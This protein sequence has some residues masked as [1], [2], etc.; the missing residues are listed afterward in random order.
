MGL[1]HIAH[2]L[3]SELSGGERQRVAIA[4]ALV[5]SPEMVLADEPT[6]NLDEA[7]ANLIF[8]LFR[9]LVR[10]EGAAVVM[11]THDKGLASQCDNIFEMAGGVI[12]NGTFDEH[13]IVQAQ[14][15]NLSLNK[16]SKDLKAKSVHRDP[17]DAKSHMYSA[18]TGSYRISETQS[19]PVAGGIGASKKAQE[20]TL[21]AAASITIEDYDLN[22]VPKSKAQ[23]DADAKAKA[24]HESTDSS[25]DSPLKDEASSKEA[26]NGASQECKAVIFDNKPK[27]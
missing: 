3:P 19:N 18:T 1:N 8:E 5:Y 17:R 11:V 13:K 12:L 27:Q 2:H 24:S 14:V 15:T 6:G 26:N 22:D 4:R 23:Q 16:E 20:D 25:T 9:E 10:D 21:K 7:N